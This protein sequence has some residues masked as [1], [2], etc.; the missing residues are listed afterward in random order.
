MLLCCLYIKLCY[1]VAFADVV[2]LI[3][4]TVSLSLALSLQIMMISIVLFRGPLQKSST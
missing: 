4:L 3:S 1:L 2:V